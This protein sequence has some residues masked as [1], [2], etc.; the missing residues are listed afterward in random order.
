[1]D[2]RA[3]W[4]A[5][6]IGKVSLLLGSDALGC[7]TFFWVVISLIHF[8]VALITNYLDDGEYNRRDHTKIWSSMYCLFY[9]PI[10]LFT[11]S[12]ELFIIIQC[13][14]VEWVF[15][16]S[17]G[18]LGVYEIVKLIG[19]A[20]EESIICPTGLMLLTQEIGMKITSKK[21]FFFE[22]TVLSFKA[23]YDIKRKQKRALK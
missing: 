6:S 20:A 16:C 3:I 1:M 7:V 23:S 22:D 17:I 2:I 4:E 11:S 9:I 12:I 19:S 21:K 8:L 10:L 13:S 14:V 18:V 15:W 5:L